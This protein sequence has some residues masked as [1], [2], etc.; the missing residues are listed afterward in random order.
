MAQPSSFLLQELTGP[1]NTLLL[2]GRAL[3]YQPLSVGGSMRA[4]FTWY[5]GN[6]RATVQML[7]AQEKPSTIRGMWKDR[8]I[9]SFT[10]PI[11]F[12]SIPAL[13]V[14]G[15]SGVAKFNNQVVG[16]VMSLAK[17]VDDFRRR[18]QLIEMGWDEIIRHGIMTDFDQTWIR[19]E[20]LEWEMVFQW[21]SQGEPIA[22]LS[23][24]F[25]IPAL[26]IANRMLAA[27]E[28]VVAAA[29]AAFALVA[30]V[31]NA[32]SSALDT[33]QEAVGAIQKTAE[34][35]N[36][37]ILA[38]VEAARTTLAALKTVKEQAREIANTVTSLPG[39]ALRND[40]D[41]AEATQQQ[42]LE[43]EDFSRE[44]RTEAR[45]LAALAARE[46]QE[47]A[48]RSTDEEVIGVVSGRAGQDLRDISTQFFG[49]P[50]EWR[51][52]ADYNNVSSSRVEA[53]QTIL[54][55]KLVIPGVL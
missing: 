7:G 44:L 34:Q 1:S 41:I 21:I 18:G 3:P 31:Q 10:D 5:P 46:A 13:P 27:F 50:D 32:I 47:L 52:I 30:S 48:A 19:R 20:D 15:Q 55:P 4:E 26:E 40:V 23:F 42:A 33:I 25:Q 17:I 11:P 54:V 51:R 24:G 22:P 36:K 37:A 12:L 16:D 8:F 14:I 49:T 39:R 6:P 28:A 53:N 35:A 45:R 38:P 29:Q 2:Q 43:A 9:K